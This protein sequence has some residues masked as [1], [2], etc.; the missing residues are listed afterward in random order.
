[1]TEQRLTT[2]TAATAATVDRT[3]LASLTADLDAIA[4]RS[5][6]GDVGSRLRAA[7]RS[8]LASLSRGPAPSTHWI[9][10]APAGFAV[11]LVLAMAWMMTAEQLG[12]IDA[13]MLADALPF[14]AYLDATLET[15]IGGGRVELIEN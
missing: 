5:S 10:W 3:H 1:M 6:G 13:D 15:D 11:V 9:N 8:A 12:S 2:P 4:D 14:D 7:R